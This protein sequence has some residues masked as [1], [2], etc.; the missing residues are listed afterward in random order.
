MDETPIGTTNLLSQPPL[1]TSP[2][3]SPPL[4]RPVRL[5]RLRL[6]SNY[7]K[8]SIEHTHPPSTHPGLPPASVA[9]TLR[10]GGRGRVLIAGIRGPHA[11]SLVLLL[12]SLFG[13]W[14]DVHRTRRDGRDGEG[15]QGWRMATHTESRTLCPSKSRRTR[16]SGTQLLKVGA[17]TIPNVRRHSG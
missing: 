17:D 13:W 16:T 12:L 14:G 11:Q 4:Q 5:R 6:R 7:R 2:H 8:L 1:L 9:H 10:L 3:T 15:W